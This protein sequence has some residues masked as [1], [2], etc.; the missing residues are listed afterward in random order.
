MAKGSS[1]ERGKCKDFS[2]WWSRGMGLGDMDD[3]FWRS[4]GSG[5]RAVNRAK[6]GKGTYG[7]CGDMMALNPVGEPLI[8]ACTFEFKKG[9]DD[10]DVLSLIDGKGKKGNLRAFIV[11]V[12]RDATRAG[13]EPVLVVHRDFRK[14]VLI[15]TTS[16]WS[17]LDDLYGLKSVEW[18]SIPF[19][20]QHY[21]VIRLEDFFRLVH[22]GFFLMEN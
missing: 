16:F 1:N 9:Y 11:Q 12:T 5:G 3:I 14:P 2:L 20:G 8:K 18:I 15:I 17:R 7:S 10:L 21:I 13:N 4:S 22:P 6:A 19:D